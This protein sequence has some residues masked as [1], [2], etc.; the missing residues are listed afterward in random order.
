MSSMQMDID[1][2]QN[3]PKFKVLDQKDMDTCTAHAVTAT[4]EIYTGRNY[5]VNDLVM[6]GSEQGEGNTVNQIH[7]IISSQ[8]QRAWLKDRKTLT[9]GY[10][11]LDFR[12]VDRD[13]FNLKRLLDASKPI[14]AGMTKVIRVEDDQYNLAL[15]NSEHVTCCGKHSIVV[16][17]YLDDDNCEGGG[18]VKILNSHGDSWGNNGYGTMSYGFFQAETVEIHAPFSQEEEL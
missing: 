11:R 9:T 6:D 8:G 18:V 12:K 5:V 16:V 14:V 3:C 17:G 4:H 7:N 1:L 10:F 13:I 2:T 15:S